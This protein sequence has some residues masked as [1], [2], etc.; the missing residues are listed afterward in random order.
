[1]PNLCDRVQHLAARL[2]FAREK[3]EEAERLRGQTREHG[4]DQHGAGARHDG[5]GQTFLLTR[6]NEHRARVAYAR[7]A[8]VGDIR[9]L[10]TRFE[11]R[12]HLLGLHA[13]VV[14]MQ[15]FRRLVDLKLLQKQSGVPRVLAVNEIDRVQRFDRAGTE[16]AQIPDGGRNQVQHQRI[17]VRRF[18]PRSRRTVDAVLSNR[19]VMVRSS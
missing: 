7:H 12:E 11:R 2:R 15:A 18:S 9:D 19:R 10:R 8:R 4:G 6:G 17:L 3:A 16:I 1:M 13:L 14:Q 5:A